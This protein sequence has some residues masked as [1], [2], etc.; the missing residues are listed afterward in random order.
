VPLPERRDQE[1]PQVVTIRE[2]KRPLFR[3]LPHLH[4]EERRVLTDQDDH[5]IQAERFG[6]LVGPRGE[7]LMALLRNVLVGTVGGDMRIR[8]D[9]EIFPKLLVNR[10]DLLLR[11]GDRIDQRHLILL[12]NV[13]DRERNA[14]IDGSNDS[15]DLVPS[16]EAGNVFDA[17]CG[18][19]LVVINDSLDFLTLVAGLVI[20]FLECKLGAHSG[21]LAIIIGATCQ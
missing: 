12:R 11:C 17:L 5:A 2:G 14:G 6:T 19:G 20:V 21:R 10:G 18:L 16:D 15:E 7:K 13:Y 4:L 9:P 1:L 8:F 3:A